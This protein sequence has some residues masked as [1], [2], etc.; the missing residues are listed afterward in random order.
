[1]VDMGCYDH[2][3]RYGQSPVIGD[4]CTSSESRA[5]LTQG[6][7]SAVASD[8]QPLSVSSSYDLSC[9][10]RQPACFHRRSRSWHGSVLRLWHPPQCTQQI[11]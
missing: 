5:S 10:A 1:M 4:L 3:L 2:P 6:A 7:L 9:Y 8:H 11:T